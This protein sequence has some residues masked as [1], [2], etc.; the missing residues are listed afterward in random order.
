[1]ISAAPRAAMR[2]ALLSRSE[3]IGMMVEGFPA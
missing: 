3:K 1:M 2:R